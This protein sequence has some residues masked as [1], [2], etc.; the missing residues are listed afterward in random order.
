[1]AMNDREGLIEAITRRV[2]A[3]LDRDPEEECADCGGLLRLPLSRQG[4]GDGQRRERF[5]SVTTAAAE[6]SLQISPPISTTPLLKPGATGPEIDRLCEEARRYNF[7]AVCVNPV[8]VRRARENLRGSNVGIASVVGFPPGCQRHRDQGD[9]SHDGP[10]A[11]GLA[12]SI[13]SSM[14]GC[15]RKATTRRSARTSP[16][17]RIHAERWV[18]SAKVI[19]EAGLLTDEEKVIACQLSKEAKADYVKTSTGLW[20]WWCDGISTSR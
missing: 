11:K 6:T 2:L 14:W 3:E 16:G 7:A 12:R 5:A 4:A 13:W 8:W 10:C 9:G 17:S 20:R 1:M 18:R 19:I 15:S